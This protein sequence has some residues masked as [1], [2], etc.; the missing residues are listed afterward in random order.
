MLFRSSI[1]SGGAFDLNAYGQVNAP[2]QNPVGTL[3]IP[4]RHPLEISFRPPRTLT[5]AAGA[6]LKL[7]NG[8]SFETHVKLADPVYAFGFSAAGLR[9]DLATNVFGYIPVP[10]LAGIRALGSDASLHLNDYFK[11][12]SATAEP[13]AGLLDPP[14]FGDIG[15]PPE[16]G[17]RKSVV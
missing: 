8:M 16:F 5:L 13:M 17:D 9:F 11:S 6:G 7:Q 10:N 15:T 12:M 14:K 3:S 4:A 2:L 1:N